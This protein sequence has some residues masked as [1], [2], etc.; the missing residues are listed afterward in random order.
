VTSAPIVASYLSSLPAYRTGV[1]PLLR[2]VEI[3]LAHGFFLVGPFIKVRLHSRISD[4]RCLKHHRS[5]AAQVTMQRLVKTQSCCWTV[6]HV[7][8][9]TVPPAQTGQ[10][11][12]DMHQAAAF[13]RAQA[14]GHATTRR[15]HKVF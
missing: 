13:Q 4:I 5:D 9:A 15:G 2:G 7:Y 6:P 1:A 10:Q 11:Q 3:G 14:T 12:R 8:S